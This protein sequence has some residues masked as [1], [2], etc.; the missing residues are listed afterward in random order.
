MKT[1]IIFPSPRKVILSFPGCQCPSIHPSIHHTPS[2]C[3][4]EQSDTGCYRDV[5]TVVIN[6]R[7]KEATLQISLSVSV[8]ANGSRTEHHQPRVCV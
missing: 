2:L 6:S 7:R 5:T 8:A 1:S 4:Q 3:R